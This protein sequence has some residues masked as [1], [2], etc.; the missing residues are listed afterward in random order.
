MEL[1]PAEG[2]PGCSAG[3]GSGSKELGPLVTLAGSGGEE[4][5]LVVSAAGHFQTV[6]VSGIGASHCQGRCEAGSAGAVLGLVRSGSKVAPT[7]QKPSCSG[8]GMA[9][10]QEGCVA[11]WRVGWN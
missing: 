11:A 7:G 8:A 6:H 3:M 10:L 2:G 4:G 1:C 5:K 9:H